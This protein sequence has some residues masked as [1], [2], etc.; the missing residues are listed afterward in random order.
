[1]IIFKI[2]AI[3]ETILIITKIIFEFLIQYLSFI[4][5]DPLIRIGFPIED[6][7]VVN[8]TNNNLLPIG[9]W[10]G[11][12]QGLYDPIEKEVSIDYDYY[13]PE[14]DDDDD[15][16]YSNGY[17]TIREISN[18]YLTIWKGVKVLKM[19]SSNL[20]YSYFNL[21]KQSVSS[22]QNCPPNLKQCGLLDTMN[23]KMCIDKDQKCP[24]NMIIHKETAVLPTEYNYTFKNVSLN[25]GTYLFFTNE[26]IDQHI[27]SEFI[28]SDAEPCINPEQAHSNFK[29]YTLENYTKTCKE[30]QGIAY[31]SRYKQLDIINKYLLYSE[32]QLI[33]TLEQLPLY[34]FENLKVQNTS[35]YYSTFIGFD[36]SVLNQKFLTRNKEGIEKIK[37]YNLIMYPGLILI[38][39]SL[40]LPLLLAILFQME[41]D[42]F[43]SYMFYCIY[44][45]EVLDIGMIILPIMGYSVLSD[46]SNNVFGYIDG[47]YYRQFYL[48]ILKGKI[49][50]MIVI[51]ENISMWYIPLIHFGLFKF[52]KWLGNKEEREREKRGNKHIKE[53]D[54]KR[55]EEEKRQK[56]LQKDY[57]TI[58]I[59]DK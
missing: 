29:S 23:H 20:D 15:D 46:I 39:I 19:E 51:N 2:F 33:S 59:S 8:D 11:T 44:I 48:P 1:M 31:N 56:L 32:N 14:K 9:E 17:E 36:K 40:H 57:Q 45:C 7:I 28:I 58:E 21:L 38:D 18:K 52:L 37:D 26:A 47:I 12:L 49:Y 6:F 16:Y 30:V 24:I 5:Y 3:I 25:D 13:Y 27:I 54:K 50:Y 35:L 55:K 34:P 10:P 42:E 53:M 41:N 43:D 22:N 4:D